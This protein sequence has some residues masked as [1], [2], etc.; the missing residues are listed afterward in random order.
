MPETEVNDV[1][2]P[3][4]TQDLGGTG[5]QENDNMIEVSLLAVGST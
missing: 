5:G 2:L 4:A 3:Q 1:A